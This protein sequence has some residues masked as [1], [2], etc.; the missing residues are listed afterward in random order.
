VTGRFISE[1][2][3]RFD[4]GIDFY[5]YVSNDPVEYIDPFG[6]I[7]YN[8]P[9][10]RTVPPTGKTL[11]ALQCL[12][13]CL[14]CQ[15]NNPTLDLLISGGAEQQGHSKH[16]YHYRGEAV[17]VSFHNPVQTYDVFQCGESC[18]FTAGQAEP[19]NS[20]WHLQLTPG[21]GAKLLP[22]LLP[23]QNKCDKNNPTCH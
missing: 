6:L 21:N 10:P 17:D 11:A 18:G 7:H 12:E 22:P 5:A 2:P 19:A 3:I 4:G 9:P 23:M 13:H 20:H 14:Q 1:D 16:S 8:H 15:T